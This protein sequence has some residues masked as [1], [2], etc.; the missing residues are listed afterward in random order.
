M[1]GAPI[2]IACIALLVG[3]SGCGKL[4]SL[5]GHG[6][7]GD[8]PAGPDGPL[9][10]LDGFEGEIDVVAKNN[11]PGATPTNVSVFAKSGKLRMDVPEEMAKGTPFGDKA[12]VIY[13][14]PAK[15]IDVVSDAQKQVLVIDLNKSGEQF[16]GFGGGAPH[17]GMPH[18][19]PANDEKP[20]KITKT[21]KYDTVAG[22]KCEYWDVTS[23]HKEGTVCIA[24]QGVSWFRIP[25]TG[26]PTTHLWMTELLDG[27]HF[28]LRFIGY[29]K[30][31]TTE[32][33][34]I[35]VTKIDKKTLP[36]SEFQY[37]PTYKVMD[38]AQLFQGLGAMPGM[39]GGMPGGM[40]GGMHGG[41]YPH[42]GPPHA[43]P[44]HPMPR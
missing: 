11:K 26:I 32:E 9:A 25:M 4:K 2:T 12:Y 30:D 40:P 20:T 39:A 27:K 21:G 13:D 14:S 24:Q 15:K 34:R 42:G 17:P 35:E 23:D 37:P 41:V 8:T 18:G 19:G 1:R 31:G 33:S 28:P 7:G 36:D 43:G 38:L 16:K 22:Y 6:D 10:F 29:E 5:E 44:A 3:A